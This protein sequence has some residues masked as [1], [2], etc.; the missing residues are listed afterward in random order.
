[1]SVAQTTTDVLCTKVVLA[2]TAYNIQKTQSLYVEQQHG[3]LHVER[4]DCL[5][6]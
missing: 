4:Q 2:S 3:A 6:K 1:M 5:D